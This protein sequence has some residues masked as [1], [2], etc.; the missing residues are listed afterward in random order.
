MI[1]HAILVSLNQSFLTMKC[2]PPPIL[3]LY[4]SLLIAVAGEMTDL[5]SIGFWGT[6]FIFMH[7]IQMHPKMMIFGSIL[8]TLRYVIHGPRTRLAPFESRWDLRRLS[9]P[10][11]CTNFYGD[12]QKFA[13]KG[14]LAEWTLNEYFIFYTLPELSMQISVVQFQLC[15]MLPA[16][17]DD[18]L[19]TM[20]PIARWLGLWAAKYSHDS[21]VILQSVS[22]SAP[23]HHSAS[24]TGSPM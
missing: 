5:K 2:R 22:V 4:K 9:S 13:P 8:H 20:R 18:C 14:W 11:V 3:R 12:S 15:T 7:D 21:Q 16:C 10:W 24:Q 1:W 17:V 6:G 23:K 19:Q